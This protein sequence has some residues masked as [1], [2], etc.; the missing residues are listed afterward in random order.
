VA[1]IG[2]DEFVAL[3]IAENEHDALLVVDRLRKNLEA[4]NLTHEHPYNLSISIGM[5]AFDPEHPCSLDRLLAV[6]DY[7]MYEEKNKKRAARNPKGK[8]SNNSY[9]AFH[10][11]R[12]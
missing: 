9:P 5:P 11:Y 3:P 7:M 1:R 10:K 4:A 6:G 2:G 12:Y 8:V